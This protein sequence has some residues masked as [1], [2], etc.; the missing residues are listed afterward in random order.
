VGSPGEQE[1]PPA[2]DHRFH[3]CRR[4]VGHLGH[5]DVVPVRWPQI[6][7]PVRTMLVVIADVLIQ[8][9]AQLPWPRR[10]ARSRPG[11]ARS[12]R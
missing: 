11:H 8:D 10:D 12:G 5:S 2:Q 4:H 3:S 7:G 9:R 6:P 1:E